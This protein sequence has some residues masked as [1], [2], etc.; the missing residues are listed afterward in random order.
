MTNANQVSRQA[1]AEQRT[2][3]I[4]Y[5]KPEDSEVSERD[6]DV[7]GWDGVYL[8]TYCRLRGEPRTFRLD[9]ILDARLLRDVFSWDPAVESF[10]RIHGWTGSVARPDSPRLAE[11]GLVSIKPTANVAQ[12]T[13]LW[14]FVVRIAGKLKR[15]L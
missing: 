10:L 1:W 11:A 4:R 12:S 7:Y 9:R 8:D 6:V 14:E 5:R 2:L 13:G 3:R 15:A